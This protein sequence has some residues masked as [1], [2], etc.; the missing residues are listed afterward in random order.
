MNLRSG[1]VAQEDGGEKRWLGVRRGSVLAKSFQGKMSV[2]QKERVGWDGNAEKAA[3]GECDAGEATQ[4][5]E[6]CGTGGSAQEKNSIGLA[7]TS[8]R[9]ESQMD[10][11]RHTRL[12]EDQFSAQDGGL[13]LRANVVFR[14][15]KVDGRP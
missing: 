7:R 11:Q 5:P 4:C 12:H 15:A 1:E 14:R 2:H 9:G 13:E 8:G 6:H 10:P 3:L